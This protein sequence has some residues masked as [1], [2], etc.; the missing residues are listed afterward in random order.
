MNGANGAGRKQI[1]LAL[2]YTWHDAPGL[3]PC[4]KELLRQDTPVGNHPVLLVLCNSVKLG[5]AI[6]AEHDGYGSCA[7][8]GRRSYPH[9]DDRGSIVCARPSITCQN[10]HRPESI[11]STRV[12]EDIRQLECSFRNMCYASSC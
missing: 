2:S 12:Y 9:Y 6:L 11:F 7:G 10:V 5:H 4:I 1:L 8:Y 3:C